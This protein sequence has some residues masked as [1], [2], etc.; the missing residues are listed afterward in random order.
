MGSRDRRTI[1]NVYCWFH[2]HKNTTHNH[3][4]KLIGL[5]LAQSLARTLHIDVLHTITVIVVRRYP[6]YAL[7]CIPY[8]D[9]VINCTVLQ[10]QSLLIPSILIVTAPLVESVLSCSCTFLQ[11]FVM[12]LP[13]SL[14]ASVCYPLTTYVSCR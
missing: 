10:C 2:Y 9:Q 7:P 5:L 4:P 3:F 8:V 13:I 11:Y 14:R 6:L 1:A 12:S